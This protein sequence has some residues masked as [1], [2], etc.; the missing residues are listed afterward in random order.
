[1]RETDANSALLNLYCSRSNMLHPE[2]NDTELL[3]KILATVEPLSHKVLYYAAKLLGDPEK[4]NYR[5]IS[6]FI[7]QSLYQAAV[8]QHRLWKY[9]GTVHYK[10]GLN[11][12]R[13]IL[14][15]LKKRWLVAGMYGRFASSF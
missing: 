12:L 14:G 10:E 13:R 9:K 11:A 1:M 8:V 4:L 15:Y 6:P 7:P 3:F 5:E 2:Q